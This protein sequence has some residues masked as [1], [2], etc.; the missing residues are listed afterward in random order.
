MRLKTSSTDRRIFCFDPNV[1][2]NNGQRRRDNNWSYHSSN[3]IGPVC[4][5]RSSQ[6]LLK[7]AIGAEL[8]TE[9]FKCC[10]TFIITVSWPLH[11]H[12]WYFIALNTNIPALFVTQYIFYFT[13]YWLWIQVDIGNLKG[14]SLY[15]AMTRDCRVHICDISWILRQVIWLF[16][17]SRNSK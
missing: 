13:F 10:I 7:W 2:S 8:E 1:L 12:M 9:N 16:P 17:N 5:E 3:H 11:W 14:S 6:R 15:S 4:H